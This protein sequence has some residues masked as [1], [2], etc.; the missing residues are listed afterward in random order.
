MDIANG[1]LMVP[2]TDADVIRKSMLNRLSIPQLERRLVA[3]DKDFE[4]AM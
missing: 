2:E 4:R 3:V 1:A